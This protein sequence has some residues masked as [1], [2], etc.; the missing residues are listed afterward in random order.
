LR[1]RCPSADRLFLW[2]G[3]NTPPPAVIPA[4]IIAH[5]ADLASRASL[6]DSSVYGSGLRKFHIFCDVF[7]IPERDRLPASYPIIHSFALW[8][9]SD[10]DPIDPAFADGTPFEPVSV[11]SAQHYVS[12]VRAWHIAQGWPPPL[13][14]ADSARLNWSL[15]GLA[16]IQKHRRTRPPRP[17]VTIPMLT[18]LRRTLILSEPFD[19]CVWAAACCA[20][21][22]MMRFGEVTVPSRAQYSPLLHLARR[23]VVFATDLRGKPYARLDLPAAKT[24]APGEIQQVFL[25][26]QVDLSPLEALRNLARVVPARADD[27]LFSWRDRAGEIRPLVRQAALDRINAVLTAWQWNTLYG[28]SFRIGGASYFL[29][30]KVSPEIVRVAGRWRS[31]AYQAYIRAFEQIASQHLARI[32][33]SSPR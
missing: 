27:P 5:I 26:D 1:P 32:A 33:S 16:Q 22:G 25:V 29:A 18:A 8:A 13:S 24:A 2:K 17:P 4:P 31:L 21:W 15:R 11:R 28:H 12:A 19:A 6:R 10:P 20:F 7:S 23:H 3:V 9:A 14:E 30:E